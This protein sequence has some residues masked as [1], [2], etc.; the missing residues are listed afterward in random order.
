MKM[1]E[2]E[3]ERENKQLI[4]DIALRLQQVRKQLNVTQKEFAESLRISNSSLCEMEAGHARLRFELIYNIIKVHNVNINY[5]LFGQGE[6]FTR[7]DNFDR[8]FE[9]KIGPEYRTFF[10]EFIEYFNKSRI[11]RTAVMN[12]FWKYLLDNDYTIDKDIRKAAG[13]NRAK[14]G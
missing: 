10:E 6:M 12:F 7:Q 1:N 8:E 13:R 9:T 11:V 5:L 2:N 3:T 14:G 4:K